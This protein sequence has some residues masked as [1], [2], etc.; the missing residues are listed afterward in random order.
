MGA[1][2]ACKPK[3]PTK[4]EKVK[5]KAKNASNLK[6]AHD[7][8]AKAKEDR[9]RAEEAVKQAM[10][11]KQQ[12]DSTAKD[13]TKKAQE[14]AFKAAKS[15]VDASKKYAKSLVKEVAKSKGKKEQ[16]VKVRTKQWEETVV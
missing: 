6:K 8:T 16:S 14:T 9:A 3:L 7:A 1:D 10:I 5:L 4:K 12:A 15:D 2:C 13:V 11:V